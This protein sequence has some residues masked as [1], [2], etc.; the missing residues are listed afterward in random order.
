MCLFFIGLGG[1]YWLFVVAFV[2]ALV[3]DAIRIATHEQ[4]NGCG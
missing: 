1:W 4:E 3:I 2:I